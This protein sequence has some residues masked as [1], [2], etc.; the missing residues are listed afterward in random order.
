MFYSLNVFAN[1][2]WL[3]G[4]DG[5]AYCFTDRRTFS[6]KPGQRTLRLV[7]RTFLVNAGSRATHSSRFKMKLLT[8]SILLNS[9]APFHANGPIYSQII[10]EIVLTF[11]ISYIFFDVFASNHDA[12]PSAEGKYILNG[13]RKP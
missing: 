13:Y 9:V 12:R 1:K 3:L 6:T 4:T 8:Y 2:T 11:T 5:G 7:E 10:F